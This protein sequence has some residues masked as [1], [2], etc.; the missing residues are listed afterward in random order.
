ML[1]KV[2]GMQIEFEKIIV[3]YYD[4]HP[5]EK[6]VKNSEFYKEMDGILGCFERCLDSMKYDLDNP[7][8]IQRTPYNY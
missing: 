6:N 3:D 4:K 2:L 8:I 1:D 5:Y 7:D